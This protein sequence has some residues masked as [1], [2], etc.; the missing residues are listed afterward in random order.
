[1]VFWMVLWLCGCHCGAP[2]VDATG[3]LPENVLVVLIDDIGVDKVGAY[4]ERYAAQ[5][6][7]I[8]ALAEEGLR[9]TNAYGAPLCS[10]ARSILLTGRHS[11]RTGIGTIT[12]R[13]SNG[14]ALA[15][16]AITIAEAL[17]TAPHSWSTAA[18]GK[19]HLAGPA[20]AGWRDHPNQQGFQRFIGTRGN[21]EYKRGGYER[22]PRNVDGTITYDE[23]YLTTGTADDAIEV[24]DTATEPFFVYVAFHA[25]H[26]P[27][28]RPP[29]ALLPNP[30]PSNARSIDKH[31]AM[32]TALDT[33]LGRLLDAMDPEVAART[34]LI[35]LGD[36]GTS[37]FGLPRKKGPPRSRIKHSV[38]EGGVRIPMIVTG[39]RVDE[40]GTRDALVHIADV[41]PT[42]ARIAGLEI[43]D[44][45]LVLPDREVEL[46]GLSLLE[47]ID[48]PAAP[49]HEF[50]YAER[51]EPNGPGPYRMDR[52]G[53]R[54]ATHRLIRGS[55]ADELYRVG[56]G[57]VGQ[58]WE[59][60]PDLFGDASLRT[61]ADDQALAELTAELDRIQ[62]TMRY[63]G[64]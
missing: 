9:F 6:P 41:F 5:T 23:R 20:W 52:R 61:E 25:S 2:S 26:V 39:P 63:E 53:I 3:T 33:E 24:L 32:V 30:L 59:E 10:P 62:Q 44:D 11:R 8:D 17:A 38:Y 43:R 37:K 12:E 64:R 19:W 55:G 36:N 21:P 34:T 45:T 14:S 40:P 4:G 51:F 29:D 58:W 18:L 42:V 27:I 15:L 16:D 50:V 60:G 54:N 46:D 47:V 48:D 13:K 28:H 57:G 7:R 22:W 1:M 56:V 49:G 31:D 35:V